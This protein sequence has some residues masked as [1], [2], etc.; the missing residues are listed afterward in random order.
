MKQESRG[1]TIAG[2]TS[3][4]VCFLFIHLGTLNYCFSPNARL[5]NPKLM[6]NR[7][8]SN[9]EADNKKQS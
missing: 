4:C 7:K 3:K 6:N 5:S 9:K 1:T 8:E 2:C